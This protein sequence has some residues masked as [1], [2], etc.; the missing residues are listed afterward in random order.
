MNKQALFQQTLL[1]K[2]GKITRL[3]PMQRKVLKVLDER[4]GNAVYPNRT[5]GDPRRK[6]RYSVKEL[7][8]TIVIASIH[9]IVITN[10]MKKGK[11]FR[12][13]IDGRVWYE[14]S[15]QVNE[16]DMLQANDSAVTAQQ[17]LNNRLSIIREQLNS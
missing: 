9:Y 14:K 17:D 15:V 5:G 4:I 7:D 11:L 16:A 12:M 8:D 10:L 3:T 1:N 6:R 2:E 13:E